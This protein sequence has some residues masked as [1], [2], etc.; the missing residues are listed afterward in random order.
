MRNRN[1]TGFTLIELLVAAAITALISIFLTQIFIT[2]VH[3]NIK[4]EQ[5]KEVK[6]N[7]D[8]AL[9]IMTRMIQNARNIA[10]IQDPDTGLPEL[11][12][13]DQNNTE[14]NVTSTACEI[15]LQ[16]SDGSSD[17][18]TSAN[19]VV[20]TTAGSNCQVNFNCITD[21]NTNVTTGVKISFILVQKSTAG[22]AYESAGIPFET[23]VTVRNH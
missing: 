21:P 7:G 11:D 23:L 17:S 22:N 3:T 1:S 9:D 5:M 20:L 4:V 12:V 15:V 10:C 14:T 2:T 16:K 8:Y 6:E 19:Q 13:T 18:L